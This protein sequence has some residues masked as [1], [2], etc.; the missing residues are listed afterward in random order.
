[1]Y[2]REGNQII[3]SE[4][5]NAHSLIWGRSGQGKTFY[6]LRKIEEEIARG[7]QV[8]VFDY[9]NSYTADELSRGNFIFQ[10]KIQSLNPF[11]REVEWKMRVR[12]L[13]S[14]VMDLKD[15]LILVLNITSYFQ[16]KLL[17]RAVKNIVGLQGKFTFSG[18]ID[19]LEQMLDSVY[20]EPGQ[21]DD[22]DNIARLLS[23][24]EPYSSIENLYIIPTPEKKV[25]MR[26]NLI[27]QF[28]DFPEMQRKFL[29][30]VFAELLWKEIRGSRRGEQQTDVILFDEFQN[31]SVCEGSAI[32]A[33]LREGR[34][35]GVS[36]ILSSQYISNYKKNEIETLLQVGNLVIF[37]PT[38]NDIK[39]TAELI[40]RTKQ[41]EWR[42]LLND[43]EVGEAVLKGSYTVNSSKRILHDPIVCK[44]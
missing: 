29:T 8:A 10:D 5:P 19:S 3:L 1:M 37:R 28:S 24:L 33:F 11:D 22:Y 14:F 16:K 39:F 44:I 15:T 41:K 43:L 6:C 17:Y 42:Q 9:T 30:E 25:D 21:K 26:G 32:S 27:L 13:E 7:K 38:D 18:V 23:R 36:V 4:I 31:M 2:D 40:M 12:S 34:K 35:F 20:A